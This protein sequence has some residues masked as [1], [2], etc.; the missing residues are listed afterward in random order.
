MPEKITGGKS[1]SSKGLPKPLIL[2]IVIFVILF[3]LGTALTV[4]GGFFAKKFAK[5][6]IESAIQKQTGVKTNLSDLEKGKMTFTDPKT[7]STVE[8]GS[9]KIPDSFP[10]DFPVYPGAKVTSSLSGNGQAEN[11]GFWLTLT[12]GDSL[13]K[14][15]SYYKD[16]LKSKGWTITSTLTT[17]TNLTLGV[18]KGSW[19]GSV[20]A[21]REGEAKETTIVIVLG[22]NSS[23]PSSAE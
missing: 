23:S 6:A 2:V 21:N 12:T 3:I 17:D 18:T 19:D 13:E 8:I 4:V 16:N 10:K 1:T 5:G 7:G 22:Q 20:T 9:E 11:G 15:S 14:V